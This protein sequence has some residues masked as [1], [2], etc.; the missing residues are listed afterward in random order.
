MKIIFSR[1]GF[2]SEFGKKP[3]PILFGI[4]PW[5][6]PIPCRNKFELRSGSKRPRYKDVVIDNIN[7][8]NLVEDL[9][10]H[11][12]PSTLSLCKPAGIQ[13]QFNYNIECPR[14][15]DYFNHTFNFL[16]KI[17]LF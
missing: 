6:L 7:M 2:D 3:S 1:K 14:P 12:I 13:K 11:K 9:T 4:R 17:I 8:G 10:N 16:F 15:F 5:S